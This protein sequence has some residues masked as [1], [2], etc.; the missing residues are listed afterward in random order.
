MRG[1]NLASWDLKHAG[2]WVLIESPKALLS[3]GARHYSGQSPRTALDL[4]AGYTLLPAMRLAA[5]D[6]ADMTIEKQWKQRTW[7]VRVRSVLGP[8]TGAVLAVH[9]CYVPAGHE[10]PAEPLVGGWEWRISPPGPEQAMRVFWSE[11]MYRLCGMRP[12]HQTNAPRYGSSHGWEGAQWLEELLVPSERAEMRRIIDRMLKSADESLIT[13]DFA[14]RSP[15]TECEHL[16]RFAAR[17]SAPEDD[18]SWWWRGVSM[19]RARETTDALPRRAAEPILD[20]VFRT[21][22]EVMFV[23]DVDYEHVYLSTDSFRT[24]G[25]ALPDDRHLPTMCHPDDL[26][27]LRQALAAAHRGQ[28]PTAVPVRMAAG[29]GEWIPL[30]LTSATVDPGHDL[31]TGQVLCRLQPWRRPPTGESSSL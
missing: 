17:R 11:D 22:D 20:A 5:L 21:T 6:A 10:I 28:A 31:G 30:L 24:L 12:Q 15:E 1:S 9:G 29:S 2:K 27:D 13:H 7:R 19:G 4:V 16:L 8:A 25:L 14:I 26:S 23:V 18:G 3:I